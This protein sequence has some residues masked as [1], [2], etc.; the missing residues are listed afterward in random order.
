MKLIILDRDGV[1]NY[2]SDDF[3]KSA[4]EW[5]PIPGSLEALARM[6]HGGYR[7]VIASNQS[8]IG[9]KLLTID[10]LNGIHRKMTRELAKL[11]V[12][13]DAIFICPHAP[14]ANCYCRKPSPGLLLEIAT[15]FQ[16]DL[17]GVPC[18]GDSWRD[19]QSALMVGAYPLLVLTG[20]GQNTYDLHRHDLNG[21][22]VLPNLLA[23]SDVLLFS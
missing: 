1:I 12:Q 22:T 11:G 5:I 15:R 14:E 23:V 2:D 8:G 6:Y 9:R 7:L 19:M 20:N 3:I 16:I 18:I 13:L 10:D 21:I 4:D 17:K